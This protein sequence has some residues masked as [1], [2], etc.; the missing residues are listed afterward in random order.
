M[1]TFRS[2]TDAAGLQIIDPVLT[3]LALN[4]RSKG[5]AY[6]QIVSNMDV[7]TNAGQ[8]PVWSLED[9][10][11][12]D[13][14]DIVD[15]RSETP[16]I[17]FSYDLKP[18]ALTP[19]RLKVT[20]TNEERSQAHS[21]LRLEQTKVRGLM[22]RFAIRRERRLAAALR[23]TT[24]GGQLTSGAGVSVKWD[25]GTSGTPAT[26]EKDIKAGR[27]AVYDA[28]GQ[29]VDTLIMSWSVAYAVALDVSIRE[30]IKYTVPGD[31]IIRD[32]EAILPKTLHGLNVVIAGGKVNTARKGATASLADIWDDNV[33]L[34]KRVPD[35]SWGEPAT[36]Y[37]LRGLVDGQ[38]PDGNGGPD[39]PG[40]LLVDRWRTPDPPVDHVRGWEKVQDL[41]VAPDV[42][43]EIADVL[44]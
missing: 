36:I 8:Y 4:Y 17:D 9:F 6:D 13:V 38:R 15:A 19:R 39:Q 44:T 34:I 42:G 3:N 31:M 22:D 33:R 7:A 27:K 11:R 25:A 40:H 10:M 32:G 28:T 12:D 14:D 30:I 1:S 21:A 23:K 5:F 37:S 43:Y 24:N 41:V 26:I 18:Y 35:N 2:T 20:I 29:M 16:E